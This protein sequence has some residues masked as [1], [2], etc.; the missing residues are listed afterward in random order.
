[1]NHVGFDANAK[2][3]FHRE[4]SEATHVGS[5]RAVDVKSQTFKMKRM[6]LPA[7][8]RIVRLAAGSRCHDHF[9][10][11]LEAQTV[12]LKRSRHIDRHR[13]AVLSTALA[14]EFLDFE[15]SQ[16]HAARNA[17]KALAAGVAAASADAA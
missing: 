11:K 9:F 14:V 5:V 16:T 15:E 3:V 7:D 17:S 2:A 6:R 8:A 1:M 13:V 10:P 12:K 4:Q